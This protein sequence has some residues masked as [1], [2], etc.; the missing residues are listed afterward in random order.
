MSAL[1]LKRA[2]TDAVMLAAEQSIATNAAIRA[3][4]SSPG[5]DMKVTEALSMIAA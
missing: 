1:Y 4:L 5:N 2:I 3:T